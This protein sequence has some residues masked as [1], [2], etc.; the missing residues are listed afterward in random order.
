MQNEKKIRLVVL[1]PQ[2]TLLETY[3]DKVTLP[4][5][6]GQF[7]VLYNHAPVI[8]SLEDGYLIYEADLRKERVYILGGFAEVDE[9]VVTVCAEV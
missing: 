2:K 7:M 9:N 6:K 1:T 8:T 4:A 3:V 5:S